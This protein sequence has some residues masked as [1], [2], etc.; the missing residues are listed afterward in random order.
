MNCTQWLVECFLK[1]LDD[2][3]RSV[4]ERPGFSKPEKSNRLLSEETIHG[5]KMTSTRL[6]SIK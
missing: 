6:L 1:Y 3:E 5:L 2:W 4:N